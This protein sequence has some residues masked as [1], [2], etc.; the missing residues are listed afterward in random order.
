[1]SDRDRY[2][3]VIDKLVE[4]TLAGR[5]RSPEQIYQ[6]LVREIR[7][8][9]GE[10]FESALAE[11]LEST[12]SALNTQTK[13]SR[14]LRALQTLQKQWERWQKDNRDTAMVSSAV[15]SILAAEPDDRLAALLGTIDPNQDRSWTGE[16]LRQ[17]AKS[18]NAEARDDGYIQQLASGLD[19][20]LNHFAQLEGDLISWM[21]ETRSSIGFGG[22]EERPGPWRSWA[23]K[24][25][26]Y[27]PRELFQTLSR[28]ASIVELASRH[29]DLSWQAT[30]EL[31]VVLQGLQRGLVTW[32]DRQ[33]YSAKTG[34]Q[35]SV[36]TFLVFASIWCQ[37]SDGFASRPILA[38]ACFQMA[39]QVLRT[40]A[41]RETFPLYG[42][43][44]ASFSGEY[45]ENTLE[46][47]EL[48]LK[49]VEGTQE[50]ARILTLLGYSQRAIGNLERAIEFHE[51]A[52]SI[53]QQAGD[54]RCEIA[55]YN[56]LS[57]LNAA[58][59][60]Y[61]EAS[62]L[63]QRALVLA[64]QVGDRL[65][66]ANALANL[67]YSQILSAQQLERLDEDTSQGSIEY[68]Q[69]GLTQSEKLEDRQSL[70]LCAYSLGLA[71]ILLER[72]SSAIPYLEKGLAAAQ[73][74]GD[75]YLQGLNFAALAEA[76]YNLQ[77]TE[78]AIGTG[79]VAAYFLDRIRASEWK[80]AA[81]LLAILQGQ[82]G[83]E[84]F[85]AE[86]ER[87]RTSIV[88]LI[89]IDGYD[90]IPNLLDRYRTGD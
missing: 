30:L 62:A 35:L 67:G 83:E 65:G 51:E 14:I 69:Q 4:S 61:T 11:R 38:D 41:R 55:S 74:S 46:Y 60:D 52:L 1:M 31:A 70:A 16:Q 90:D 13:A 20:G 73:A 32:F 68:L 84:A 34:K 89:G 45:L 57:R 15:R 82:L 80:Q 40:F 39:L 25:D 71:Y 49:R 54:R 21:Y 12:E 17:L 81:G 7:P 77:D 44:F 86:L 47:L 33:P 63:S 42:G 27:F 18:L 76:Y 66:A 9:T 85:R 2:F 36:S 75:L 87:N 5:I 56:H 28:G 43:V 72:P 23:Q 78:R 19:D 29:T 88:A 10:L 8:G 6:R 64:R 22:T 37:L 79:S 53:A 3:S 58:A 24:T 50:K 59:K 26:A 48:P